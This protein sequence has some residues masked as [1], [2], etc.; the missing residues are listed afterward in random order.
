MLPDFHWSSKNW[1]AAYGD[2]LYFSHFGA[3]AGGRRAVIRDL[4]TG[5]ELNLPVPIVAAEWSAAGDE[6]LGFTP[7]E[8]LYICDVGALECD[9]II[10]SDEQVQ[11]RRP[12]WSR[13]E[14]RIFYLRYSEKG[15]CCTLWSIKRD[16]TENT[17]LVEL[18]G[19][20]LSNSYFGVAQDGTVFYNHPDKSTAEIWL[21]AID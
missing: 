17:K 3:E 11:G 21:V 15:E 8:G 2:R 5:D 16:G 20:E 19:F 10:N 9:S 18:T 6:L 1:G 7:E 4:V 12:R 13:D 14:Q